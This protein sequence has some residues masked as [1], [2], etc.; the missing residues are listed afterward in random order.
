M[1]ILPNYDK[2]Y[3]QEKTGGKGRGAILKEGE[4][5]SL[6]HHETGVSAD[7]LTVIIAEFMLESIYLLANI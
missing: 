3:R 1:G 5:F 2:R 4:K 7:L 6:G